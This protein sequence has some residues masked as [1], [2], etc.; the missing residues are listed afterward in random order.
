M[1]ITFADGRE[2]EFPKAVTNA[3]AAFAR[4]DAS[5]GQQRICLQVIFQLTQPLVL[6]AGIK[7]GEREVGMADGARLVGL[8][9]AQLVGGEA[10]WTLKHLG[11]LNDDG[12]D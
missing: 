8:Q 7:A 10:P 11:D 1:K 12:R 4:G 9:I 6:Q 5:G 3:F 2:A